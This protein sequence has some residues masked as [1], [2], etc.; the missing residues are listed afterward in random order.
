LE[1]ERIAWQE[2]YS[3]AAVIAG[4]G[5]RAYYAKTGYKLDTGAGGFMIKRWFDIW[6]Y[7]IGV[8]VICMIGFLLWRLKN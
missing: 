5:T 8:S 1:A 2:G 4:I 7:I 6:Y 3:G